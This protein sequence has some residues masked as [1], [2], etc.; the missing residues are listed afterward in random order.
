MTDQTNDPSH[1]REGMPGVRDLEAAIPFTRPGLAGEDCEIRVRVPAID[2]Q[3]ARMIA[4]V[5]AEHVASAAP[6]NGPSWVPTG[7]IRITDV[8][9]SPSPAELIE[10]AEHWRRIVTVIA[11]KYP[12]MVQVTGDEY[13][14]ADTGQLVL[15]PMDDNTMAFATKDTAVG[16]RDSLPRPPLP[17]ADPDAPLPPTY[18]GHPDPD[19]RQMAVYDLP[20]F[21]SKAI[22][23]LHEGQWMPIA[24]AAVNDDLKVIATCLPP[25]KSYEDVELGG[26][27]IMVTVRPTA[28]EAQASDL[29]A[30]GVHTRQVLT[31]DGWWTVALAELMGEKYK[32]VMVRKPPGQGP[33]QG[34]GEENREHRTVLYAD[35]E[36]VLLREAPADWCWWS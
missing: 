26:L 34:R 30:A 25:D 17:A 27:G 12:M 31:A 15:L 16:D 13:A 32:T 24:R 10:Q 14:A 29:P 11:G 8:D 19:V 23:L 33:T 6:T 35:G 2:E 28:V 20:L 7:E 36:P 21:P 4:G 5:I 9:D 1:T 22:E 18:G 3:G